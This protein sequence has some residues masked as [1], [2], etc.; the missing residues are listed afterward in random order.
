MVDKAITVMKYMSDINR[1]YSLVGKEFSIIYNI[2]TYIKDNIKKENRVSVGE[3][4]LS[5]I[6]QSEDIKKLENIY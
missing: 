6:L 1:S 4:L 3:E 2:V 5:N